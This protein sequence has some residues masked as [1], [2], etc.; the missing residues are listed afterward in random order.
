MRNFNRSNL[1]RNENE[2][3]HTIR[4]QFALSRSNA[5]GRSADV[6]TEVP[7]RAGNRSRNGLKTVAGIFLPL[8]RVTHEHPHLAGRV[9]NGRSGFSTAVIRLMCRWWPFVGLK[10]G[11]TAANVMRPVSAIGVRRTRQ[12]KVEAKRPTVEL[13]ERQTNH[14]LKS[15]VVCLAHSLPLSSVKPE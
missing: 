2:T 13:V 15:G 6:S 14:F 5:T 1:D 3:N 8:N 10:R 12:F 7:V 4:F 11:V 9:V